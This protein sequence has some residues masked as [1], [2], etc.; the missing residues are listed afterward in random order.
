MKLWLLRPSEE[1]PE[2]TKSPWEPWK[3]TVVGFV[4]RAEME[5]DARGLADAEAGDE[6]NDD[7]WLDEQLS[8]CVELT[9]DGPAEVVIQDFWSAC[10]TTTAP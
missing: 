10:A 9:A 1:F 4:V 6:G 2:G 3:D 5:E 7:P 8:T